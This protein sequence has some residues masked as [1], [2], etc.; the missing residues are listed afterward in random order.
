MTLMRS[1]RLRLALLVLAGSIAA[2]PATKPTTKPATRPTT[3]KVAIAKPVG[4]ELW[5]QI[6]QRRDH[7]LRLNALERARV[8]LI[9]DRP[10]EQLEALNALAQAATI[11]FDRAPFAELI[12]QRLKSDNADVRAAALRLLTAFEP[13]QD[14]LSLITPLVGD[15]SPK[16]RSVVA[17]AL[18]RANA[19]VGSAELDAATDKL[20]DDPDKTVRKE[21]LRSLWGVDVSEAIDAKLIALSKLPDTQQDAIYYALTTR[22]MIR[23][24]VAARLI[25]LLDDPSQAGRVTW[26]LRNAIDPAAVASVQAALLQAL[27]DSLDSYVRENCVMALARMPSPEVQDALQKIVDDSEDDQ[28]IR[29]AAARA[30]RGG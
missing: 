29:D 22:P 25:E 4:D 24:A 3:A 9:G 13:T 21:T 17:L 10:Q 8:M 14:D 7:A 5:R 15:P 20:L 6:A 23:P 16:V 1:R 2:A 19:K 11:K 27:G 18:T 26:S 12:R 28:R 30:L